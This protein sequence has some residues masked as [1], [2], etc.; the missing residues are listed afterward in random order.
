MEVV[1]FLYPWSMFF[2]VGLRVG[3]VHDLSLDNVSWAMLTIGEER[4][5]LGEYPRHSCSFPLLI[6]GLVTVLGTLY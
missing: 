6:E 1:S 5:V 2:K 3:T 4:R